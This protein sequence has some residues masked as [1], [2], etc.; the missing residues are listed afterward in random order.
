MASAIPIQN[1]RGQQDTSYNLSGSPSSP[2]TL[3]PIHSYIHSNIGV[4]R[5]KVLKPLDYSEIKLLLVENI[6]AEAVQAFR[7]SGFQVD[8]FTKSW[9]EDELV[10]KI[11]QY[12]AIGIRSKTRITERVL[13]A[14]TKVSF[15]RA[16]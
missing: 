3:S 8:H 9:S 4:T 10:A 7:K 6:S 11:G 2:V 13:Q 15:F 14:A 5:P 16:A 1:G 12:H